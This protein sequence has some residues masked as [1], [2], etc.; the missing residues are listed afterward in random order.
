MGQVVGA[1]DS[2]AE[3]PTSRPCT[4]G[5]VLATMYHVLGIDIH[6]PFFDP[7]QRPLP[8]LNEGRAIEELV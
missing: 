4:P 5:C 6:H 1:T 2:R 7:A 3:Y 8:V